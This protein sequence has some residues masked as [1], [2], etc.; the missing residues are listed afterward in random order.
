MR[1]RLDA[2]LERDRWSRDDRVRFHD[3]RRQLYVAFLSEAT[4]LRE[5]ALWLRDNY[6]RASVEQIQEAKPDSDQYLKAGRR[7]LATIDLIGGEGVKN[8]SLTLWMVALSGPSIMMSPFRKQD[9]RSL[10]ESAKAVDEIF[11][12]PYERC[13]NAMRE[14]L[15]LPPATSKAVG[16]L[17]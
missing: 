3:Q 4:A 11:R 5:Y 16:A 8:A 14:D 10:L 2:E 1:R 13:I 6:G 12:E 7:H 17:Y 9:P 15:G